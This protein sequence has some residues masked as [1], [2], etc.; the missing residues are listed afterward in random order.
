MPAP[1]LQAMDITTALIPVRHDVMLSYDCGP[2]LLRHLL[3]EAPGRLR[4]V[5]WHHQQ[6]AVLFIPTPAPDFGRNPI[7]LRPGHGPHD[8]PNS[9]LH[10]HGIRRRQTPARRYISGSLPQILPLA[11]HGRTPAGQGRHL[12]ALAHELHDP[13]PQHAFHRRIF[14]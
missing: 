13:P 9:A 6:R 10:A 12:L 5:C 14:A 3:Q 2:R 1:G 7:F 11:T 8:I 4:T